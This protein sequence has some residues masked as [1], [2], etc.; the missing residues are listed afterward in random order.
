[1]QDMV[2]VAGDCE[3]PGIGA[4]GLPSPLRGGVGGGGLQAQLPPWL[5]PRKEIITLIEP[6]SS[7]NKTGGGFG[8]LPIFQ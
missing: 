2:W 8:I 7:E 4:V 1:M 5:L 6:G 3:F